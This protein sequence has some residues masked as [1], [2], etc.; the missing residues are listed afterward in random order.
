MGMASVSAYSQERGV[1]EQ[2]AHTSVAKRIH[3]LVSLLLVVELPGLFK[4]PHRL[5]LD[6]RPLVP[7]AKVEAIE[8]EDAGHTEIFEDL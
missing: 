6:A 2:S 5:G 7:L 4:S 8:Y 1:Q 3:H